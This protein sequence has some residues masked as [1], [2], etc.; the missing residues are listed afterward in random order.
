M[1]LSSVLHIEKTKIWRNV[2]FFQQ[3]SL[4]EKV[5]DKVQAFFL[6]S[7]AKNYP[8][9]TES[10]MRP[11]SFTL[12]LITMRCAFPCFSSLISW[13][14]YARH[15]L[16]III[17]LACTTVFNDRLYL[18]KL[19]FLHKVILCAYFYHYLWHRRMMTVH[20]P[21]FSCNCSPVVT[22]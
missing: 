1:L 2:N 21:S 17:K 7:L 4:P 9:P 10:Q 3:V 8:H 11:N 5:K 6:Q 16:P 22:K 13:L 15:V 14:W 20:R 19:Y 18:R 12:H